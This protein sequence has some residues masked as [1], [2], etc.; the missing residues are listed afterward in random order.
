MIFFSN[1][2]KSIV[3]TSSILSHCVVDFASKNDD[4]LRNFVTNKMYTEEVKTDILRVENVGRQVYEQFVDERL[5]EGDEIPHVTAK[6]SK[7]KLK[8]A[9]YCNKTAKQKVNEELIEVKGH[10]DL[11]GRCALVAKSNRDLD[12]KEVIGSH[13][14]DAVPRS[15][16]CADGSLHE[17]HVNKHHLIDELTKGYTINVVTSQPSALRKVVIINA[18]VIVQKITNAKKNLKE[19]KTCEDLS[20]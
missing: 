18:M 14:L 6:I 12:M 7:L 13:E 5:N 19:I 20:S 2:Q 10:R 16:M 8:V 15:L 3:H 1:Y 4:M 11:F 17:G 9:S